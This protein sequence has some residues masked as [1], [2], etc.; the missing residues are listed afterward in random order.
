[1]PERYTRLLTEDA[2]ESID[3]KWPQAPVVQFQLQAFA[4]AHPG[5]GAPSWSRFKAHRRNEQ[6]L[7]CPRPLTRRMRLETL[8]KGA[9]NKACRLTTKVS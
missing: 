8:G 6:A 2:F 3:V 5:P 9:E 1:M 4:W 7:F